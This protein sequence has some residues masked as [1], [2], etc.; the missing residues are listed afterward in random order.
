MS[1]EAYF[2]LRLMRYNKWNVPRR[3]ACKAIRGPGRGASLELSLR[4][5]LFPIPFVF[6]FGSEQPATRILR[7]KHFSF[8][9]LML[10]STELG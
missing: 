10:A 6:P 1:S 5:H 9:F 8:H 3:T 4:I 2:L 7:S